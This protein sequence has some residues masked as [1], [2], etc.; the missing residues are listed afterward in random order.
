[1][2]HRDMLTQQVFMPIFERKTHMDA[3]YKHYPIIFNLLALKSV[4]QKT[5]KKTNPI[6][7]LCTWIPRWL[8]RNRANKCLKPQ[9][10]R[11]FLTLRILALTLM[12][13]LQGEKLSFPRGALQE[14]W[15]EQSRGIHSVT[16]TLTATPRLSERVTAHGASQGLM[17]T[18]EHFTHSA[19][20]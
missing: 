7:V 3:R 8:A 4:F 18:I 1:M 9:Q 15:E 19:W 17:E 2:Q 20:F 14:K 11:V 5:K 16:S 13:L 12:L 6:G 10:N